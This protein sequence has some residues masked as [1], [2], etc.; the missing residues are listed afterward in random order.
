M[1]TDNIALFKAL[2]AKMKYL[3]QQQRVIS[4][5]VANADTPGYIPQQLKE[6]NFDAMVRNTVTGSDLFPTT[7]DP[8]HFPQT[9]RM[10]LIRE[11][12]QDSFYDVEPSG[13]AV[14]LEEQMVKS[15]KNIMDYNLITA[16]Y[17]KNMNLMRMAIRGSS[18]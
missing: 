10:A 16:L 13:N 8:K 3:D 4:Q 12:D 5:N 17:R 18:Q 6:V 7:T 9:N 15:G 2:N 14:V 1:T 11:T